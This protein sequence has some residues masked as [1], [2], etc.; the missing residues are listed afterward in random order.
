MRPEWAA[1]AT[2]AAKAAKPTP[3]DHTA[4]I[5]DKIS[6]AKNEAGG[7]A[8]PKSISAEDPRPSVVSLDEQLQ[9]PTRFQ[10]AL[11]KGGPLPEPE[12]TA[13]AV[14]SGPLPEPELVPEATAGDPLPEPEPAAEVAASDPSPEPEPAAVLP[15][16]VP[17]V[18]MTPREPEPQPAAV[19]EPA[20]EPE[21]AAEAA[22]SN[23]SNPLPEPAAEVARSAYD[24]LQVE[25]VEE[26][27]REDLTRELWSLRLRALNKRAE[28]MGISDAELDEV[29]DGASA[30]ANMIA[31]IL[32]AAAQNPEPAEP[33]P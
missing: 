32:K 12:P 15:E 1:A 10:A 5:A 20:G 24:Y 23:P 14:A 6:S 19:D 17:E 3:T 2:A 31:L 16:P 30:K 25:E 33:E 27:A 7:N 4:A 28:A 29:M 13:E 26:D 21:P 8:T 22:P 18:S 9:N 11:F